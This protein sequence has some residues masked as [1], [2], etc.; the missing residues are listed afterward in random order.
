MARFYGLALLSAAA[1]QNAYPGLFALSNG[2]NLLRGSPA[3]GGADPGWASR[4]L[5]DPACDDCWAGGTTFSGFDVPAGIYA[6]SSAFC[7]YNA[8]SVTINDAVGWASASSTQVAPNPDAP[9]PLGGV[10]FSASSA[11]QSVASAT[12]NGAATLLLATAECDVATLALDAGHYPFHLTTDA[13]QGLSSLP[14]LSPDPR[15]LAA[16]GAFVE[17]FGTHVA[18][19]VTLGGFAAQSSVF[20][21]A[22]FTLVTSLTDSVSAAASL[23]LL[24][25]FG[26]GGDA[27]G[28]R[29]WSDYLLFSASLERNATAC[30][31]ACPPVSPTVAVDPGQ[32][33]AALSY[34]GAPGT[35]PPV[36]VRAT[37]VPITAALRGG[38]AAE[39]AARGG[40]RLA[41]QRLRAAA[42]AVADLDAFLNN[43]Y[44]ASVPG[45]GVPR[46]VPHLA[47]AAALPLLPSGRAG[48]AGGLLG[49][50]GGA[51]VVAGGDAACAAPPP[52]QPQP[53]AEVWVSDLASPGSGWCVAPSF[54]LPAG[55]FSSQHRH[56]HTHTCTSRTRKDDVPGGGVAY[57]ASMVSG[58][59]GGAQALLVVG[60]WGAGGATAATR[61]LWLSSNA[62][63]PQGSLAGG[64]RAGAAFAVHQGQL[65]LAGGTGNGSNALAS[66]ECVALPAP[67]GAPASAPCAAGT[68]AA[69][70]AGGLVGAA[71][72]AL[73][74][75]P[76]SGAG[77]AALVLAGG[78]VG[79]PAL[80]FG[81]GPAAC[82]APG[83]ASA[84]VWLAE[85][86]G[87]RAGAWQSLSPLPWGAAGLTLFE[88]G[89]GGALW[90]VGGAPGG[91]VARLM[92]AQGGWM[93]V[94]WADPWGVAWGTVAGSGGLLLRLG[95]CNASGSAAVIAEVTGGLWTAGV[96][97]S[98]EVTAAV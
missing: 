4:A 22:N 33:A 72:L 71:A 9:G 30:R 1:A 74:A 21:A 73:A 28:S 26:A 27:G 47:P 56:T 14:P 18:D 86:A 80:P 79:A 88:E 13:L 77:G 54:K 82:A 97:P 68:P 69:L 40:G 93:A 2:Y 76:L 65:V 32:W 46:S 50:P 24:I 49:G 36:P 62:W 63:A 98:G 60:G 48:A 42:R 81:G 87:A 19:S 41:P 16:Y 8:T 10:A 59:E 67:G 75:S 91:A 83:G 35:V 6:S 39:A 29:T 17:A 61:A 7:T 58:A 38:L 55:P 84:A 96:G 11:S 51:L 94:P 15:V 78:C 92:W 85:A 43:S 20:T 70:P 23:S 44:C 12:L 89:G 5:F 52:A 66:V 37:L 25:F 57:A 90:A 45:C 34:G 3:S 64:A 53:L 95:G 31:P